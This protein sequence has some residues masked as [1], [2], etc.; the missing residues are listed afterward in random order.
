[1]K[2]GKD[3]GKDS[4]NKDSGTLKFSD[5]D[6][7]EEGGGGGG[8]VSGKEAPTTNVKGRSSIEA[9]LQD[10]KPSERGGGGKDRRDLPMSQEPAGCWAWL[11]CCT[12]GSGDADA[13]GGSLGKRKLLP[14]IHTS[15][16]HATGCSSA[17]LVL[18]CGRLHVARFSC[19]SGSCCPP[20]NCLV[21]LQLW[22][23]WPLAVWG[24]MVMMMYA[25]GYKLLQSV[26]GLM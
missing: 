24:P 4:S 23:I 26:G 13:E 15:V 22:L 12:R 17:E 8:A 10:M 20:Y 2:E 21:C 11:T 16:S 9:R 6:D 7:V 19:L 1:V 5:K 3:G 25:I 18:C 14:S